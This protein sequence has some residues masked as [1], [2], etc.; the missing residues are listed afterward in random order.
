MKVI[1]KNVSIL[2]CVSSDEELSQMKTL[3]MFSKTR[4]SLTD[5]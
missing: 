4:Q 3:K 5:N 1:F 2:K